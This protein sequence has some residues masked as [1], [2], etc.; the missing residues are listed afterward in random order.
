MWYV[1]KAFKNKNKIGTKQQKTRKQD[2]KRDEIQIENRISKL[3]Y[4]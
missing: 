2:T 4:I 1:Y 3:E